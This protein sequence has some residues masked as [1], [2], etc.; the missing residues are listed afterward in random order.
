MLLRVSD[1]RHFVLFFTACAIAVGLCLTAFSRVAA[2]GNATGN[3]GRHTIQGR[4]YGPN[5]RRTA[6]VNIRVRLVSY[7]TGDLTTYAD[8][9]GS[10]SFKSLTAG[11]YTIIVDGNEGF[12]DFHERVIIDDVGSKIG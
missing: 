10:F 7:N 9:N 1:G 5:G 8:G 3:G 6:I 11:S 2:Q 4:I 12:E